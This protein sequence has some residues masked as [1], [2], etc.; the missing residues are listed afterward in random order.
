MTLHSSSGLG[1][2]PDGS[3]Q[4]RPFS[5]RRQTRRSLERVSIAWNHAIEKDSL[6][7]KI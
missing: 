2:L 7:I 4:G 5:Y 1:S 3:V 6:Q